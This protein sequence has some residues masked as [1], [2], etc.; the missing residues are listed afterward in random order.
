MLSA[1]VH[2]EMFNTNLI[3]FERPL[4][5]CGVHDADSVECTSTTMLLF[6][7]QQGAI[8]KYSYG[9]A[10]S[11]DRIVHVDLQALKEN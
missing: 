6:Q 8:G 10:D 11:H 7:V 2:T 4:K 9:W 1:S 5:L 3:G